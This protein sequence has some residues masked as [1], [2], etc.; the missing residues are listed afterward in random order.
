MSNQVTF[1]FKSA[2]ALAENQNA[3]EDLPVLHLYR[4]EVNPNPSDVIIQALAAVL[5]CDRALKSTDHQ[6]GLLRVHREPLNA[7]FSS[8]G[9]APDIIVV[10]VERS[11]RCKH[12]SVSWQT[13]NLQDDHVI[14]QRA[15]HLSETEALWVRKKK[16]KK[17]L[18]F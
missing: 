7:V 6:T 1:N 11:C 14:S 10:S 5:E 3:S 16:K 13:H 4:E 12:Q 9:E 15:V 2:S 17:I 8:V 18:H